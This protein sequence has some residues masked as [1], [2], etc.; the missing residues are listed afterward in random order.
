MSRECD[1]A[2]GFYMPLLKSQLRFFLICTYVKRKTGCAPQVDFSENA[3]IGSQY[4]I[5]FCAYYNKDSV[6]AFTTYTFFFNFELLEEV[7]I[8]SDGAGSQFKQKCLFSNLLAWQ[9]KVIWSFNGTLLQLLM[10]RE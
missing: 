2:I 8:F 9:Q 1:N 3:T 6:C 10:V 5:K 4:E 7:N